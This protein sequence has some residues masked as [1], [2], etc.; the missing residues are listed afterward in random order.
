[1]WDKGEERR[2]KESNRGKRKD[3]YDGNRL[4]GGGERRKERTRRGEERGKKR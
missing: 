4:E 1:M 3:T 2:E